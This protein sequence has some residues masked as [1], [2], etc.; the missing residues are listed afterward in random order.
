[1]TP[2][3]SRRELDVLRAAA[4]GLTQRKT[5][6]ALGISTSTVSHH[7]QEAYY[8]LDVHGIGEAIAVAMA[9]GLLPPEGAA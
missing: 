2:P 6:E 7:R 4:R 1:M 3:L 8:R 5:A 9:R